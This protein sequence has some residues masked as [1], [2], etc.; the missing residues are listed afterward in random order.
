M[1]RLPTSTPHL[2]HRPA[3]FRHGPA[4][5][6]ACRNQSTYYSFVVAEPSA[7]EGARA[8][9]FSVL[10]TLRTIEGAARL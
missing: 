3:L 10:I 9:D 8:G 1:G 5:P 2:C 7:Q 4:P 6:A